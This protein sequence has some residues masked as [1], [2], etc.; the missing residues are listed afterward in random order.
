MYTWEEGGNF[1]GVLRRE[2]KFR[3]EKFAQENNY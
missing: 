1:K 2:V 3:L